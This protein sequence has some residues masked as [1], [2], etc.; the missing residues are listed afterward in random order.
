MTYTSFIEIVR[1]KL[2]NEAE[3][4]QIRTRNR[5]KH[6]VIVMKIST[7]ENSKIGMVFEMD[8]YYH[9]YSKGKAIDDIVKEIREIYIVNKS[10][11]ENKVLLNDIGRL[12]DYNQYKNCISLQLMDVKM[13][14]ELLD[15]CIWEP[16]LNLAL[17]PYIDL[18]NKSIIITKSILDFWNV[19]KEFVF[20]EA[21]ANTFAMNK[22]VIMEVDNILR[23][24]AHVPIENSNL[25]V[26]SNSTHSFGA[27]FLAY[28]KAL[29]YIGEKLGENFWIIPS[30]VHEC[31]LFKESDYFADIKQILDMIK[32][33]NQ[34]FCRPEEVLTNS[35]YFYDIEKKEVLF[36]ESD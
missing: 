20:S 1:E 6:T 15:L 16:F 18:Q 12:E 29:E 10:K 23:M 26:F 36:K 25:L 31:L 13:N 22:I 11:K 5:G 35:I 3:L 27:V 8:E 2:G 30:S 19:P 24:I 32:E 14:Q 28:D 17:V 7:L 21:K 33:V 34:S 9:E 4:H